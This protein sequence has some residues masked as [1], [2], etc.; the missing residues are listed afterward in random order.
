MCWSYQ[1]SDRLRHV[2]SFD[3]KSAPRIY[4]KTF[5]LESPNLLLLV[6]TGIVYSDVGYDVGIY[7]R[8]EVITKKLLKIPPQAALGGIS[9]ERFKLRSRNF[10][11]LSSTTCSTNLL[12]TTSS[13]AFGL[14]QNVIKHCTKCEKTGPA[15]QRVE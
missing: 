15:R 8:S 12:E 5:D 3:T 13:A 9:R 2:R 14:L 11:H 4:R 7:F 10:T 1:P 6:H